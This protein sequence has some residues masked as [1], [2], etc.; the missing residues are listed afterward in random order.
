MSHNGNLFK[1]S[2]VGSLIALEIKLRGLSDSL[3]AFEKL[4]KATISFVISFLSA[5]PSVRVKHV[6]CHLPAFFLI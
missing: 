6:G 3:G 4:S 1:K 5:H 2:T